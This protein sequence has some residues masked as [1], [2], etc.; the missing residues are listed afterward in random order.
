[1]L[2]KH[3]RTLEFIIILSVLGF[4]VF[5]ILKIEEKPPR[6]SV[7][8]F[9]ISEQASKHN[10]K[11]L[12]TFNYDDEAVLGQKKGTNIYYGSE[13]RNYKNLEKPLKYHK[14]WNKFETILSSGT[15]TLLSELD[16]EIL[17]NDSLENRKR[18]NHKSSSKSEDVIEF[19]NKRYKK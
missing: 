19:V 18:G 13:F 9:E 17:K 6:R 16:D 14:S 7:I 11:I 8:K 1:M 3:L 4:C 10:E 15:D 5:K 2:K 12:K